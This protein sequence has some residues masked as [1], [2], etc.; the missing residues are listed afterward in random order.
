MAERHIREGEE[1]VALQREIVQQLVQLGE[2]TELAMETL[3][4]FEDLLEQHRQYF[5]KLQNSG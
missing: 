1:H 5:A 3:R 4:I 2:P